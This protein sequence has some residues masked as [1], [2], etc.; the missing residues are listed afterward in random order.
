MDKKKRRPAPERRDEW[1]EGKFGDED[2][3]VKMRKCWRKKW[4]E[5]A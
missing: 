1:P 3:K 4:G 2:K 5:F